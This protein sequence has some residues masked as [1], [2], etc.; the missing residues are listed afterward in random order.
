MK[1]FRIN[2]SHKCFNN[3]LWILRRGLVSYSVEGGVKFNGAKGMIRRSKN[4]SNYCWIGVDCVLGGD[5]GSSTCSNYGYD[6]GETSFWNG[7]ID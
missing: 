6:T 2:E 5:F 1:L 4:G 7:W 3:V